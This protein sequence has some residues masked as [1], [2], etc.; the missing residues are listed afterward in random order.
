MELVVL[1]LSLVLLVVV[2]VV[3][4]GPL[5]AHLEPRAGGTAPTAPVESA[6]RD[7]LEAAREAK[8]REVRD[9]EMDF[10]TGKLSREDYEAIDGTLRAEAL[11]ILDALERVNA[12]GATHS[13]ADEREAD[14]QAK[15]S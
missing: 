13:P 7:E 15:G 12:E 4:S 11:R 10:R 1:F 3:I 14:S 5:R 9:A 6:E 8:Y 2:I